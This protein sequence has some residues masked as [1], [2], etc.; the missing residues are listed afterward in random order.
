MPCAFVFTS[1][2]SISNSS[3]ISTN[4][5]KS[6]SVRRIFL[7]LLPEPLTT[8]EQRKLMIPAYQLCHSSLSNFLTIVQ[9][10]LFTGH[11]KEYITPKESSLSL[12]WA[13]LESVKQLIALCLD[14][15]R[16]NHL[17][18]WRSPLSKRTGNYNKYLID[19][20]WH[21][22]YCA[23]YLSWATL[24]FIFFKICV[25]S[26]YKILESL[27][28]VSTNLMWIVLTHIKLRSSWIIWPTMINISE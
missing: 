4:F 11:C 5:K 13:F 23:T 20:M 16:S 3:A 8:F 24:I 9:D 28:S 7:H 10:V 27:V 21:P 17:H 22:N 1:K 14:L 2:A 19:L 25:L 12:P 15:C 18:V 6:K 26:C